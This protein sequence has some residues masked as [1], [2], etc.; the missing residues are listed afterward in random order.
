[1]K[2]R[3]MQVIKIKRENGR[4]LIDNLIMTDIHVMHL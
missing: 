4:S 1:M 2:Y 3:D